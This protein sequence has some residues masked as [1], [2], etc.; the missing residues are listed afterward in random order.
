MKKAFLVGLNLYQCGQNLSGCV[1]DCLNIQNLLKSQFGFADAD[2]RL[3]TD[4]QATTQAILDGLNWLV[5]GLGI[6]DKACYWQSSHGVIA[7]GSDPSEPDG[8][9][10]ALC[11]YD[12][13]WSMPKMITDKQL[14]AVF[15]QV[16]TGAVL[17][18]GLDACHSGHDDRGMGPGVG[19]LVKAIQPPKLVQDAIDACRKRK[20]QRRSIVPLGMPPNIQFLSGCQSNQTSADTSFNGSAC[21]AMT[22]SFLRSIKGQA[23]S[24]L[25]LDMRTW[26]KV[27]GYSQAPNAD[28]GLIAQP[29]L[30]K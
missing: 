5:S 22:T 14:N 29:W 27:N 19:Y 3:I 20:L 13:D 6:G 16:P 25:A 24:Q 8:L 1:N 15:M 7:P 10:D 12:F 2:I 4:A 11:T 9:V 26:L 21:G 18:V 17:S 23:V 30:G 28:G